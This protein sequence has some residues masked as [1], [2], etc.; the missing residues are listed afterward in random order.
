M[1]DTLTQA[2]V[3]WQIIEASQ[4]MAFA[5]TTLPL[6]HHLILFHF[7]ILP[8][9]PLGSTCAAH[10]PLQ[11]GLLPQDKHCKLNRALH[12]FQQAPRSSRSQRRT[13]CLTCTEGAHDDAA[14]ILLSNADMLMNGRQ[15]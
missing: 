15:E 11:L 1:N 8:G 4:Y 5:C 14:A 13:S 7:I 10:L 2:K 6:L 9:T 3:I 12:G